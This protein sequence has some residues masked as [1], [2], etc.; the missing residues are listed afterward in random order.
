MSIRTEIDGDSEEAV[1]F[2]LLQLVARAEGKADFSGDI[3][4]VDRDWLLDT[5]AECL[6]A[7]NGERDPRL[8]DD[9]EEDEDGEAVEDSD[10]DE[11]DEDDEDDED[12]DE[13]AADDEDDDE[14][15]R[16]A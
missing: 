13:D 1:A 9:D 12:A 10:E 3:R 14:P 4:G 16:A 2:A 6:A 7:V 8:D 5:Y 15:Q 11:G